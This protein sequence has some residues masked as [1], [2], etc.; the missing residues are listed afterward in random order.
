[1]HA[2]QF[3]QDKEQESW[4]W[5]LNSSLLEFLR[6]TVTTSHHM[7]GGGSPHQHINY[8]NESW[9]SQSLNTNNGSSIGIYTD[10]TFQATA[11]FQTNKMHT[12]NN[13]KITVFHFMMYMRCSIN[14]Y[15]SPFPEYCWNPKNLG[16]K[17]HNS[18]GTKNPYVNKLPKKRDLF[19]A[20]WSLG[21]APRPA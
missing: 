5:I 14:P 11:V 19:S 21:Q 7:R 10:L 16:K 8:K 9:R 2:S 18:W 3:L 4:I 13:S 1:M 12:C 15:S 20:I 6:N 17:M